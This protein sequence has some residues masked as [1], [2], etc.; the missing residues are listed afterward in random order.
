MLGQ[1][2]KRHESEGSPVAVD[3]IV[4]V[5]TVGCDNVVEEPCVIGCVVKLTVDVSVLDSV[6]VVDTCVVVGTMKVVL[7]CT[8]ADSVVWVTVCVGKGAVVGCWVNVAVVEIG[9]GVVVQAPAV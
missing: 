7:L 5:N 3:C 9:Y 2:R 1:P 4:L 8:V 6:N